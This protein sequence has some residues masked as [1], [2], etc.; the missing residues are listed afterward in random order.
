MNKDADFDA[1]V[2]Q[3]NQDPGMPEAGY[4]ICEGYPSFVE[5]FVNDGMALANIGDVSQPSYSDYGCHIIK[6]VGDLTAGAYEAEA[7]LAEMK[8]GML[9]EAQDK[10]FEEKL[11]QWISEADVKIEL[12]KLTK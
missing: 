10:V 1:L 6:Y 8:A 9:S 7:G 3:Y 11:N 2:A 12:D 4:V 5:S